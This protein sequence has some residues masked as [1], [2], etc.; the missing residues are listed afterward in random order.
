MGRTKPNKPSKS[1]NKSIEEDEEQDPSINVTPQPATARKDTTE[2]EQADTPEMKSY[3][4]NTQIKDIYKD[5]SSMMKHMAKL[6]RER[7]LKGLQALY[8]EDDLLTTSN[9]QGNNI[10]KP[11]MRHESSPT[12]DDRKIGN[13]KID[14]NNS[15]SRSI[16][17]QLRPTSI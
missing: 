4:T 16:H 11:G 8:R 9:T 5:N 1:P 17:H 7:K 3:R 14:L 12:Q 13:T 15:N 6:N 10:S 2:T